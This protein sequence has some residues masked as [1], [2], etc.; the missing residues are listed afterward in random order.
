MKTM[1][2]ESNYLMIGLVTSVSC[3]VISAL[4][5]LLIAWIGG[6]QLVSGACAAFMPGFPLGIALGIAYAGAVHDEENKW[7]K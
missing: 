1:K 3:M 4:V 2:T 5:G 6:F 7:S